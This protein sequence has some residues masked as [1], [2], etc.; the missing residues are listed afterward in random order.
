MG[1]LW[2]ADSFLSFLVLVESSYAGSITSWN[3]TVRTIFRVEKA[4]TQF[5][6]SLQVNDHTP[7]I[8]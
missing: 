3:K 2:L 5:R 6:G 4:S 7:E 8:F 1:L